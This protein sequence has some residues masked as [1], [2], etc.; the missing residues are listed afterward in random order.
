VGSKKGCITRRTK[1]ANT[2]GPNRS[3]KRTATERQSASKRQKTHFS[4]SV[5]MDE[6]PNTHRNLEQSDT[7]NMQHPSIESFHKVQSPSDKVS[8]SQQEKRDLRSEVHEYQEVSAEELA[9]DE[10]PSDLPDSPLDKAFEVM[11]DGHWVDEEI[12]DWSEST[13]VT[14]EP[15]FV[16]NTLSYSSMEFGRLREPEEL[17]EYG[18]LDEDDLSCLE[19]HLH[20][21]N[22]LQ[23]D[24]YDRVNSCLKSGSLPPEERGTHDK[25]GD[26][27]E[28]SGH[29]HASVALRDTSRSS[30]FEQARLACSA[31]SHPEDQVEFTSGMFQK[32]FKSP[33]KLTPIV[34]PPFPQLT[35]D[36][37]PV[38]GISPRAVLRTCFRV[39][40]AFNAGAQAIREHKDMIVELYARVNSSHR[41]IDG[42]KQHFQLFDLYHDRPPYLNATFDL[43]RNSELWDRDAR[44]FLD[45]EES[46]M[47]RCVGRMKRDEQH[48]MSLVILNIWEATW[49]NVEFVKGIL[50]GGSS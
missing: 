37:S 33:I 20:A 32:P 26:S 11:T 12:Q 13:F 15:I 47:C 19:S 41:E 31:G 4:N 5:S 48:K 42:I 7:S 23:K 10:H 29:Q 18:G 14:D 16:V 30:A 49:K 8:S 35:R 27:A 43:W 25:V 24:K 17:D 9:N 1:M 36:R 2:S 3:S 39:G 40:E 45:S 34:R 38:I 22:T 28:T 21:T 6:K 46:K 50:G 44:V